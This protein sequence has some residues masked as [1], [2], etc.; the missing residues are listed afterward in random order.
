MVF[1]RH[2]CHNHIDIY[3][4]ISF[5]ENIT[6]PAWYYVEKMRVFGTTCLKFYDIM[7]YY[8]L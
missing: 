6:L 1:K 4:G 5:K 8:F 7:V 2:I 3:F